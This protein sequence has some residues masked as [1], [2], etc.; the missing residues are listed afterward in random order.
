MP[1]LGE[2]A[3]EL[4]E[5]HVTPVRV[6]HDCTDGF[7]SACWRGVAISATPESAL[8]PGFTKPAAEERLLFATP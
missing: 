3:N 7:F 6:A 4:G 1:P 8:S 5:F 2:L